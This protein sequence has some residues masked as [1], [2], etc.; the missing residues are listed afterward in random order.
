MRTSAAFLQ[1]ALVFAALITHTLGDDIRIQQEKLI[2][3]ENCSA[4]GI[5]ENEINDAWDSAND[6]AYYSSGGISWDTSAARQ[7]LGNETI[8]EPWHKDM[9][10]KQWL[11]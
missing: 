1:S 11:H 6:I 2:G 3:F 9:K 4:A 10:G 8:N 7:Y 5:S